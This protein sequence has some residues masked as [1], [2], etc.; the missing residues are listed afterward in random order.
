VTWTFF[1]L[2][3]FVWVFV[4]VILHESAHLL[5]ARL[6]G[7][8]AFAV[9]IGSGPLLLRGRLGNIAVRVHALPMFGVVWTRPVL[10]GLR[11]KG[12]LFA[13]SGLLSDALLLAGLLYL[14][15]HRLGP[16]SSWD[17]LFAGLAFY[18]AVII[19]A[20]FF[21]LDFTAQGTKMANDGRQFFSYLRGRR[22]AA[23]Q[24]HERNVIRY[25][26]AFRL[27]DSWLM[28][29]EVPML[30]TMAEAQEDITGGRYTDGADK[31]LGVIGQPDIHPGEKAMLLDRIACMVLYHDVKVLLRAAEGWA[32][33]ACELVPR[34]ITLRGTLG[35]VLVERGSYTEGLMLL[36][37][38]T[39]AGNAS[40]DRTLSACYSAKALHQLGRTAEAQEHLR[41]AR[42]GGEFPAIRERI[43]AELGSA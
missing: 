1:A 17:S 24:E 32:R 37:P 15:G 16:P 18:Q 30:T 11:W 12:A 43:E 33:E 26:P 4:Q 41:T 7:F 39:G 8:S 21:P 34:S 5:A 3:L 27:E 22:P 42:Q 9:T 14:A 28:R 36:T 35:A 13:I 2:G 38:L 31:Y 20:N 25:D 19:V 29:C 23:L 6:V 10:E 40:V